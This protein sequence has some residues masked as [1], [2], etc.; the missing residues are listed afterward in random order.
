MYSDNF[1]FMPFFVPTIT[2]TMFA[3][4]PERPKIVSQKNNHMLICHTFSHI[5][6][7]MVFMLED[8]NSLTL[9]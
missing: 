8:N 4:L 2:A 6:C 7:V 5:H 9:A 3:T 1:L